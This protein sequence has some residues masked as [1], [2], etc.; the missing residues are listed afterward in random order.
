M[1][2]KFEIIKEKSENAFELY[3]KNH[4]E[5]FKF[6]HHEVYKKEYKKISK[7]CQDE[8]S[9]KYK[10][11]E[12]ALLGREEENFTPKRIIVIQMYESEKIKEKKEKILKEKD[13]K[14]KILMKEIQEMEN[15]MLEKASIQFKVNENKIEQIE[16]LI[17]MKY[18]RILFDSRIF[19]YK[20]YI[21]KFNEIIM[22]K[23]NI[24]ILIETMDNNK[25][26]LFIQKEIKTNQ[27]KD[28][29]SFIF[30]F[31]ENNSI[32]PFELKEDKKEEIILKIKEEKEEELFIIGNNELIIG[33]ERF[34]SKINQ[35]ANS[36]F[37]YL[38][39]D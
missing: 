1:I 23:S 14:E 21:T 20:K 35:N 2:E 28:L 8:P 37:D 25:I 15:K 4:P 12:N 29:N 32:I 11:K 10:G 33:K 3:G 36:F 22:N 39:I 9:Y 30:T 34:E 17:L 5:L 13:K 38:D 27:I 24:I 6:G 26:G 18:K 16:E 7:C 19:N 31:D